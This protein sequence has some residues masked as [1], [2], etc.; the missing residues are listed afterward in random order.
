MS[1]VFEKLAQ[2]LSAGQRLPLN[3]AG[4]FFRLSAAAYPVS[5]SLLKNQRIIGTMQ[6]LLAGDYVNGVEFDGV[7]I[8]NGATAQD[9]TIQIAGGGAGSD[10]V[11]GEVSVINGEL[12]RVKAGACFIGPVNQAG[13]A[14][15]YSYTELWNPA[16]SGKNLILNKISAQCLTAAVSLYVARHNAA[17]ATLAGNGI[18]KITSGGT[19]AAE[20]RAGT[21]A[22]LVGAPMGYFAI[23]AAS[24]SKDF[25][26]SEPLI[27]QPGAGV[28]VNTLLF[29]VN[30]SATFQWIE[31]SV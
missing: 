27:I 9:V 8:D 17:L 13:V 28:L 14:G 30:L 6:N 2:S 29:N 5:V 11:L 20:L 26:F 10:R 12:A 1:L 23:A 22:V 3:I 31:E 21:N 25:D 24:D 16:G 7:I 15:Q 4:D 19:G 18:S